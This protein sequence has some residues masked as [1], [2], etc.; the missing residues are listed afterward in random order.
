MRYTALLLLLP[1]FMQAQDHPATN[2]YL[3]NYRQVND[4]LFKFSKP[5]FLTGYNKGGYNN[6]PSF[7]N[8]HILYLTTLSPGLDKPDIVKL[9]LAERTVSKVTA[10]EYGEYSPTN[11]F[12]TGQFSAVTT[13]PDGVQRLWKMPV[14]RSERGEPILKDLTNVGYHFWLNSSKVALFMVDDPHYLAIAD[15]NDNSSIKLTSHIGRCFQRN[16]NGN[17][18]Y[19]YK[20]T[21]ATWYIQEL[22]LRDYKSKIIAKTKPGAEDFVILRDGTFVMGKNSTLYKFHPSYD[23]AWLPI[24]DLANYG[25][26]K[27]TRLAVNNT[28]KL[29]IVSE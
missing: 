29:A 8:D 21:D 15:V 5:K 24:V 4:S 22:N 16:I 1:F 11:I 6:Q 12:N 18:T 13:E 14:D 20:A 9:N 10:T 27:I 7:F 2:V 19:I 3:F 17:L 28:G 23:K 25:I 26:T